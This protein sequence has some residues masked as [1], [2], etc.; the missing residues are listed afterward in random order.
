[1]KAVTTEQIRQLD[2]GT[3]AAGTP[4]AE[5]MERAGYA[6]ARTTMGFLRR[7]DARSVLLL[8]GKGNKG[9]DAIVTA[10]HLAGAGCQAALVLLCQR[11]ELQGDALQHFQKLVNA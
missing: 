4:G 1:M 9:G 3:I 7:K 2:Q 11:N 6:V 8:A 10:R 5:L